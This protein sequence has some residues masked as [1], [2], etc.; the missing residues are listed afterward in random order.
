MGDEKDNM[1]LTFDI[2]TMNEGSKEEKALEHTRATNY[3][4]EEAKNAYNSLVLR[5]TG[6][7]ED[8]DAYTNHLQDKE[9][10]KQS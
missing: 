5:N 9:T 3:T 6:A 4:S 8:I 10:F 2:S 7:R 1:K